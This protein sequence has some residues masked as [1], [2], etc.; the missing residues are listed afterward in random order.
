MVMISEEARIA[1]EAKVYKSYLSEKQTDEA[2]I[3]I[4]LK[5]IENIAKQS[6]VYLVDM[7]P[8]KK[9]EDS[10]SSKYY[11]RINLEAQMEEVMNFFY[12]ITVFKQ[13][14]K[15]E[16]YQLRPKSEGSSI[17]SCNIFISKAIV[18]E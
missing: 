1:E 18:Q 7:K 10:V 13:L 5:E 4:F 8:T 3:T 2:A 17:I 9:S 15:I 16:E 12:Y 6:S 11:V 14:I